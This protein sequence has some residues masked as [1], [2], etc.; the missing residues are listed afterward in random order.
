MK[1]TFTYGLNKVTNRWEVY[2]WNS[3]LVFTEQVPDIIKSL[4]THNRAWSAAHRLNVR[5]HNYS[6]NTPDTKRTDVTIVTTVEV[7]IL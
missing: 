7:I 2:K 1:N 4:S 6:S 3:D 5:E